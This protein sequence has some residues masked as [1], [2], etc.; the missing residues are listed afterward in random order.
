M[1][2]VPFQNRYLRKSNTKFYFKERKPHLNC[3][4]HFSKG[5][6][7]E[8]VKNKNALEFEIEKDGGITL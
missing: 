2:K 5:V 8:M 3:G 7:K 1:R 6:Y 4:K